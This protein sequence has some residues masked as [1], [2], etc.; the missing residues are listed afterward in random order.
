MS[1]IWHE[2]FQSPTQPYTGYS[3][4][5]QKQNYYYSGSTLYVPTGWEKFNNQGN[6]TGTQ[7]TTGYWYTDTNTNKAVGATGTSKWS[8]SLSNFHHATRGW[9]AA[10]QGTMSSSTGPNDGIETNNDGSVSSAAQVDGQQYLLLETSNIN[11]SS[12][13]STTPLRNTQLIRTNSIDLTSYSATDTIVLNGYFHMY[14]NTMGALGVACTK[15]NVDYHAG[16]VRSGPDTSIQNGAF[17]GAGFT[18]YTNDNGD[19]LGGGGCTIKYDGNGDG[20][21]NVTGKKRIVG[22]QQT[23]NSADYRKFQADLTGAGGQTV[24]I[25]FL[26]E[27]LTSR[28]TIWGSGSSSQ[29]YRGDMALAGLTVEQ[30]SS[31]D[32]DH[33][34]GKIFNI[35]GSSIIN[36]MN[37]DLDEDD[38][39]LNTAGAAAASWGVK[40][41][42][43]T[44][45]A[46]GFDSDFDGAFGSFQIRKANGSWDS[47]SGADADYGV[48][49]TVNQLLNVPDLYDVGT[50]ANVN[51]ITSGYPHNGWTIIDDHLSA[52]SANSL[53]HTG[54]T[55][56]TVL[57][58]FFQ[59]T[60]QHY[61]TFKMQDST[62]GVAEFTFNWE[63]A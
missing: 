7:I 1:I 54:A 63:K 60:G 44:A 11:A 38:K 29:Y 30:I 40:V 19:G 18:G 42:H 31:N 27:M 53:S 12:Y 17:S 45:E 24:Y 14:G 32:S 34:A 43:Q 57:W 51:L 21:L 25:Y 62:P 41:T 13:S 61:F 10:E 59:Y 46:G 49:D 20:V 56:T 16:D 5:Q 3:T 48:G 9:V 52:P 15:T 33:Y 22:E 35:A 58:L 39:V 26:A 6:G 55:Y 37:T 28:T 50:N 4:N 36:I 47:L 8:T 2:N 23:S